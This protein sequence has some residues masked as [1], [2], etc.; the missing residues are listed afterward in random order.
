MCGQPAHF[1][2]SCIHLV[3]KYTA[4]F[5]S[6]HHLQVTFPEFWV[7]GGFLITSFLQFPSV[8]AYFLTR[9]LKVFC[10]KMW[11]TN[12]SCVCP[13]ICSFEFGYKQI[14]SKQSGQKR[15]S[16]TSK[17]DTRL[18]WLSQDS[19]NRTIPDMTIMWNVGM[20]AVFQPHSCSFSGY[21]NPSNSINVVHWIKGALY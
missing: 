7:W 16:N 13:V 3:P 10:S 4:S 12:G 19:R 1:R 5:P 8:S 15:G 21:F 9:E 18:I 11:Y 2:E 17:S 6:C 14:F 20:T